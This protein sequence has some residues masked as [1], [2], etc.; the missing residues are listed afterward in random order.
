[1]FRSRSTDADNNIGLDGTDLGDV[2]LILGAITGRA[3][4][5]QPAAHIGT[6]CPFA[7]GVHVLSDAD[8]QSGDA[9]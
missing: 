1:M 8:Q 3:A 2:C 6:T 9:M 4:K 7:R 5:H